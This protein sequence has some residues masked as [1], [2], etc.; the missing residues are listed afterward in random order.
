[1]KT[2]FR[3]CA[4]VLC[5]LAVSCGSKAP[6]APAEGYRPSEAVR[7]LN[8]DAVKAMKDGHPEQALKALDAA[9][10]NDPKFYQ[11]YANKAS[12]LAIMKRDAE[13]L[14]V[15]TTLF[16]LQPTYLDARIPYALLLERA[17]KKADARRA[18]E[19]A[20]GQF[21]RMAKEKPDEPG[22]ATHEA[23]A[24][25]LL[26]R[27]DDASKVIA[28]ALVKHPNDVLANSVK[29]KI[30]KGDREAFVNAPGISPATMAK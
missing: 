26:D 7:K 30:E 17:G 22:Y 14:D 25:L 23:I 12:A 19:T 6:P 11:A 27:K 9:I 15:L 24:L 5:L 2:A 13:A 21:S 8:N 28:D 3:A 18:Y 29:L 16:K 20:L 4:L 1:M 10:A